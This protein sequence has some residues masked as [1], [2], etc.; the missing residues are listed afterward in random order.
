MKLAL[1]S[2]FLNRPDTGSGQYLLH[3]VE[4]LSRP[5][6]GVSAQLFQPPTGRNADKLSFE[7]L[8]FP[9]A[10]RAIRADLAHVPYFGSAL[11]PRVPTV[12]TIHDLIPIVLP[13]YRGS[14]KVRAY[15]ELV[16]RAARRAHAIIA[17]SE[18]SK[19]DIVRRL[20]IGLWRAS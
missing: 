3:L 7:Q 8:G 1:N 10:A 11:W 14:L 18:A 5:D 16:S 12:V 19:R 4:E 6:S 17:D 13:A 2:A 9:R 15:T 20:S